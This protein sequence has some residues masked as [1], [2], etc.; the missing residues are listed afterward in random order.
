[1]APLIALYETF[2]LAA[3]FLLF[4]EYV[5]PD[6]NTRLGY[7]GTLENRK[8]KSQFMPSKGYTV[9]PGG[10]QKWYQRKVVFVFLYVIVDTICTILVEV[11]EAAGTFC[12]TSWSPKF[13]HIWDEVITN[14]FLGAAI[15][16]IVLFYGRFS[17]EPDFAQHKPGLKLISFKL[18]VFINFVR[19]ALYCVH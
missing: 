14:V 18:V 1:M 5:A 8:P 12:E 6:E 16:S 15:T 9:I 2:G 13:F 3:L 11:T 4:V 17:K 19:G 10:S 7:F